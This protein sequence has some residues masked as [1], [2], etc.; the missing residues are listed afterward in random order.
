MKKLILK[1]LDIIR[2]NFSHGTRAEYLKIVGN[3]RRIE[4]E[5]KRPVGILADMPG[6][7]LRVKNLKTELTVKNGDTVNITAK[8]D[9]TCSEFGL[10][11][12]VLLKALKKGDC[13]F[14]SDG[15]IKL[16]CIKTSFDSALCRVIAGGTVKNGAGLNFPETDLPIPSVTASDCAN[17]LF[18]VENGI[19]FIGLSFVKD[20][21][22]IEGVR[23]FLK[24]RGKRTFIVA[25]IER[26]AAIKNLSGIIKTADGI[27]VAR[28]DLGVE[29]PI[30]KIALLQKDIINKCNISGKP[31]IT[32]TQML[33]SMIENPT[34][35]RAESTDVANAILDGTDAV[36]LSG[37][38]AVGKYPVKAVETMVKISK[39][40]EKHYPFNKNIPFAGKHGLS[41]IISEN[42]SNISISYGTKAIVIPTVSG[43]TPRFVSRHRPCSMIVALAV[44]KKIQRQLTLSWGI[45]P[46]LTKKH[47]EAHTVLVKADN[48]ARNFPIFKR[49]D[50]IIISAGMLDKD[51]K[52]SNIIKITK[53]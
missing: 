4:S 28:G 20:S 31:V 34:P 25:K 8:K 27:M 46:V 17:I 16:R 9:C 1:G 12:P 43:A 15:K 13:I 33:E 30:E 18:A 14:I 53:I 10:S 47:T 39:E 2:I 45:Y 26:K 48:F 49:N 23:K 50:K 44:D 29:M 38:T 19:D 52:L 6:P 42:V 36:M 22:D 41:D 40:I 32:A 37:E 3:A 21:A 11:H 24:N 35:T 5:I 51:G 7:K